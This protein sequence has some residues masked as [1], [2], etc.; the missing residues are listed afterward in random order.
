LHANAQVAAVPLIVNSQPITVDS[1]LV[2]TNVVVATFTDPVGFEPASAFSARIDWGDGY[3]TFGQITEDGVFLHGGVQCTVRA[4][5]TFA[6]PGRFTV[7]TTVYEGNGGQAVLAGAQIGNVHERL[8]GGI[9]QDVLQRN[10]DPG[11]L[12]YWSGQ[13][14]HGV[15]RTVVAAQLIHSDEYYGN[16][17]VVP[18]YSRYL[19]RTPDAAGTAFWVDQL[20]RHGLTDEQ[21][22][23]SFIGSPEF[24][25]HA[26]GTDQRWVDAMYQGLLGRQADQEGENFWTGQ[27]A[28]GAQRSG[29]AYGF[30]ASLER[31]RQRVGGDYLHYLGRTA[32]LQGIDFWVGLFAH[33]KTNEDL[34]TGIVASDEYFMKQTS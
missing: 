5:H 17:I 30:A 20:A 8:V 1:G 18:A 23:A 21:L 7:S 15:A 10:V 6:A 26:G 14:A 31:E 2:A 4:S 3:T 12:D 32:D 29:V 22:E 33:G 28:Q 25:Q 27:L 19:G 24:Y 9:Y 16:V 13:L 11:G 34:I